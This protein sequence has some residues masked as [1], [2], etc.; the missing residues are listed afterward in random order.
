MR[1]ISSKKTKRRIAL[2]FVFAFMFSNLLSL[3]GPSARAAITITAPAAGT[4]F[5]Q[6]GTVVSGGLVTVY[7]IGTIQISLTAGEITPAQDASGTSTGTNNAAARATDTDGTIS[8]TGAVVGNVV[9]IAP[10]VGTNFVIVPGFQ[11]T[12]GNANNLLAATNVSITNAK[13]TDSTTGAPESDLGVSVG[14]VT[15]GTAGIGKAIIAIARDADTGGTSFAGTETYPKANTGSNTATISLNGL[16]IAIPPSG[17]VALSGTL[18]ATLESTPPSGIGAPAVQAANGTSGLGVAG[19]GTVASAIA[20]LTGTI[21]LCVLT[22]AAGQIQAELDTDTDTTDLYD[23]QAAAANLLALN[24]LATSTVA[25]HAFDTRTIAAPTDLVNGVL[26][27][28]VDLEPILIRGT[29]GTGTS[30]RDQVFQ[31][32]GLLQDVD[33][34]AEFP[35]AGQLDTTAY[36][37]SSSATQNPI[38][39]SFSDDNATAVGTLQAVDIN[40]G[41]TTAGSNNPTATGFGGQ[42]ARSGFLGALRAAVLTANNATTC[43]NQAAGTSWGIASVSGGPTHPVIQEASVANTIATTSTLGG[44]SI[45]GNMALEPFND[46]LVDL[47]ILCTSS[48]NPV[49]GWFAILSSGGTTHFGFG[50]LS[51]TA[52]DN[53]AQVIKT[54][55]AGGKVAVSNATPSVTL[56]TQ[57]LTQITGTNPAISFT[58]G[59]ENMDGAAN[60]T[61]GSDNAIL[62]AF[63]T[64]NQLSIF[65]IQN[66][67]DATRDVIAITPRILVTNVSNTLTSDVNLVAQV[68]G[69]N[70]TGTTTLNLAKLV[71]APPSVS[72]L[73]SAQGVAVS[74]EGQLGIDCSSGGTANLTLSNVTS[75]TLNTAVLAACTSGAIAPAPAFFTGGANN[76]V[77]GTTV[78]NG[79]PVVQG[80]PRGI[81]IKEATATGFSEQV[82]QIG[83]S[84]TGTLFEVSLPNGCDVIDDK[85]DNNTASSSSSTA[86]TLGGNDLTMITLATTAGVTAL[87]TGGAGD[88]LLTSSN[89]LASAIGTTPAKV[90][91]RLSSATGTGT[92]AATTDAILVKFDSQDILCPTTVSGDLVSTVTVQNKVSASTVSSSVGPVTGLMSISL[93]SATKALSF[94]FAD[95]VATSTKGEMSTNTMIGSTPRLTTGGGVSTSH[96]FKITELSVKGIPVGGRFSARN[97]DPDNSLLSTVLTRGQLWVIPAS[98]SAFSTAPAAADV[99]FSDDSLAID[100][101]PLLVT[102]TTVDTNAPIGTLIIGVKKNT[103][104]GAADPATSTTTVTVKN[105]K[106]TT[107]NSSTTDLVASVEFYSQDVGVVINTPGAASANSASSP[108]L[109]TPFTQGTTKALTQLEAAGVQLSGSLS[110]L[111]LTNRLAVLETP[112]VTQFATQIASAMNADGTK[113]TTSAVAVSS[114]GTPATDN[115]VTVTGTA[116]A[117]D[118]GAEVTISTGATTTYDSVTVVSSDNGS[119]TGN[120][121]GD[122]AAPS[123]SVSVTVVGK[124]SSTATTS[125]TKTAL[126]GG[127]GGGPSVDDVFNEIAGSDGTATISE[128]L[129][130]V[131]AQGGLASIVSSGGSKLA[132][133]IKAAKAALGLS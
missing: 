62:Y 63:C 44:G 94:G 7:S 71:G 12:A 125:V 97:L 34:V 114:G 33:V 121:R 43:A 99:T 9:A 38:V 98:G 30:A 18:A 58:G 69:N 77:S 109:F 133:V 108:T 41:T 126:C 132:G 10:P 37:G 91:F 13:S 112:Q 17:E 60:D 45:L 103:A 1:L 84:V 120:V 95:D 39:I 56:F 40:L 118:N 46:N 124:V 110:N 29:A 49:A 22:S 64:N 53:R 68:R 57:S 93:G 102:G 5:Q 52:G 42:T 131:T 115:V 83:G 3:F 75:G 21:N 67:F 90:R 14:V 105:L 20:G 100:G 92:D 80:E 73:T 6:A 70:L 76:T 61:S 119:F 85:D 32:A 74:E 36:F 16:G 101:V 54:S 72:T 31:T 79:S 86:G 4:C 96:P 23:K 87:L 78:I 88:A 59:R 81:L 26:G 65:P 19:V 117:V 11:S 111:L 113:I 130:Y 104:T 82:A 48:T 89:V 122:C 47:R 27:G 55:Q 51:G 107:A 35:S 28:Y 128:V 25:V 8:N 129:S 50:T 66:G 123:T 106:L 116:G 15:N 24:Q 2:V 127:G